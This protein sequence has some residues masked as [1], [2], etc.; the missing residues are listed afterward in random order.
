MYILGNRIVI[1]G[2]ASGTANSSLSPMTG[3]S[4]Y[5]ITRSNH[6]N[7][8]GLH[9]GVSGAKPVYYPTKVLGATK[10]KGIQPHPLA[11]TRT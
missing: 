8:P 6:V 11:I 2:S 3:L 4:L 1:P 9:Q 5:H 10:S 7:I